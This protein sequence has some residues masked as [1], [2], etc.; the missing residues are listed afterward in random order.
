MSDNNDS[1]FQ[2]STKRITTSSLF[3]KDNI[4]TSTVINS[5][6]YIT[7]NIMLK[8]SQEISDELYYSQLTIQKSLP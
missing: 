3:V 2:Y 4:R 6:L 1:K 8:R 7:F 5:Q